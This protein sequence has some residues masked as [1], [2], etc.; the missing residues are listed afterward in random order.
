MTAG[1]LYYSGF[2]DSDLNVGGDGTSNRNFSGG[3]GIYLYNGSPGAYAEIRS[4][5]L[6]TNRNFDFPDDSGVIALEGWVQSQGYLTSYS[7]TD[8]LQTV[9]TRGATT[10]TSITAAGVIRSTSSFGWAMG[11]I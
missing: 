4:S 5:N 9:T 10:T 7:E 2:I 8:T 3:V 1:R 11:S 6:T